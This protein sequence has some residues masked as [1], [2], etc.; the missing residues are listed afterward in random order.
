[1]GARFATGIIFWAIVAIFIHF[2]ADAGTNR[3]DEQRT[4][5]V[6]VIAGCIATAWT[7]LHRAAEEAARSEKF[8]LMWHEKANGAP[9][10]PQQP[11]YST[12]REVKPVDGQTFAY[13]KAKGDEDEIREAMPRMDAATA[14]AAARE[15]RRKGGSMKL[16][17]DLLNTKKKASRRQSNGKAA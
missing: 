10:A 1:M 7:A 2:Y 8:G 4:A 13:E 6:L 9:I 11:Q 5:A 12:W 17:L 3:L 15:V 16:V 14:A